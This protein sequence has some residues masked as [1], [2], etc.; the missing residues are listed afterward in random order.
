MLYPTQCCDGVLHSL[1]GPQ[2]QLQLSSAPVTL[3]TTAPAYTWG[4]DLAAQ[5]LCPVGSAVVTPT[6]GTALAKTGYS[7]V[8][9]TP[10]PLYPALREPEEEDQLR[11]QW[12]ECLASCYTTAISALVAWHTGGGSGA[13]GLCIAS[14]LL[15]CGARGAPV[16]EGAEAAAQGLLDL[17]LAPGPGLPCHTTVGLFTRDNKEAGIV[18]GVFSRTLGLTAV[19]Q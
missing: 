11:E 16:E 8:A 17:V 5:E 14:P 15:G 19:L 9:H 7:A 6:G 1:A 12:R 4:E 13:G 3:S 18:G 10:P 2:L